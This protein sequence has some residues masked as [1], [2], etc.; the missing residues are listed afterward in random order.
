M[1]LTSHIIKIFGKIIRN[2]FIPTSKKINSSTQGGMNFVSSLSQFLLH[3][4]MLLN[5]LAEGKN[6]DIVFLD[7]AI[8]FDG[9]L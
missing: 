5:Q 8:V 1:A 6:T 3:Y 9:I 2:I 4:D 7:F